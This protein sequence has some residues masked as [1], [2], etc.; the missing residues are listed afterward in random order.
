MGTAF[1]I[2]FCGHRAN[3]ISQWCQ[4]ARGGNADLDSESVHEVGG[5]DSPAFGVHKGEG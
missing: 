2:P 5:S 4:L 1:A 3:F